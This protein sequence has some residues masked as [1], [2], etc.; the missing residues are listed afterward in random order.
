MNNS[1]PKKQVNDYVLLFSAGAALSV[2]FL[3]L[4]SYIFPEGEIIGGRRV[5]ENIPKSIQY[6]FYILSASSIFISGYLF[7]L[8][9]KNWSRGSEEKRKVKISDRIFSFFDGILMRTTLR[10]KAAG[11]MHSMIYL[12]FL[13]LFAGT[14]TLEIHHLMPPSLKFLQGTTYIV[15]SFLLELA[16]LLYLAGLVWAFYRR[17]FGTEDRIKTKTKMDDYLTLSLL[18][19][20]GVSGL[21]TEAGRII[22]EGFPSYEKWSFVGYFIATLLPLESGV[23][24]HRISWILHTVS[25]FVFLLVLPQSKLR[26]I[27]TSPVNMYLSPKERPKGAMRDIGN[28]MEAEDIETVGAELIENF[29]W[30]QLLD[31]DACT[32]CGRCSSVC[33][34]NLTGK[35]LDPREIIL[36]VGQVMS[37]T[38]NPAVPTTVSTPIDLKVKSSSVFER[39]TPE[40]LWACTSC[41]ACDEI[42]PVNIEI[43]DKI[44]DMRRYLALMASDFPSELGKAYVAMENSSN[45]WG[46]SQ[47][48]R[49]K[50][51]EDLDF[52]V[53][54]LDEKNKEEIDYLYWIGCA[55]AFDD[56]NVP[57]T[58]AVATLLRRANV[59]YAVLGP[60][61]VCTGDSARRT[62]NEFVFQQLAIQ[63]IETMNNL[64]VKKV[65]TQ[66]P[67]C[68]NTIKN[69]YPQLGGNFEV[70]HHS[71]LLTELVQSGHIE[72]GT[73]DKPHVITYHDSCY[74]GRHNDIYTAPREIVGSIGGIEIREMKRQGTTSFCCGAGGGRMW[75]EEATGKKVNIERVE[76]AVETGADEVAV[77]CPFCYIMMDDGMKEI[78][79]GD[80]VRVRDVS[81]ILLDNLRKD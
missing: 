15:Y 10:F 14:I 18:A 32:V 17:I 71:Q 42:C 79:Q 8:R 54:L 5:F 77:A 61:E 6:I 69:E 3:W 66:C 57:V 21:T 59:S 55:G 22:V 12:G 45:P 19:F 60:K 53:P 39:I 67:H 16:S 46:A 41:K 81:L 38:G 70:I 28:L 76:E 36:K 47:E 2:V 35:P 65:I 13:G 34:A 9:A 40:E 27:I 58:R 52:E 25:F 56:R 62:G 23:L 31:L 80:N 78:G 44:L 48:D 43:L 33:P 4:A 50:W 75:M 1:K 24:F 37:E 30:K 73:S 11:L 7:S 68:F 72:V 74:L 26:H 63:N 20:M 51:S 64:D 29:T 49:M